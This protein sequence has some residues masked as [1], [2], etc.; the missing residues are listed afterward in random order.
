[1]VL[2]NWTPTCKNKSE[3]RHKPYTFRNSE[4][5]ID[6]SVKCKPIKF[7]E[8]N[9]RENLGD[10]RYGNAFLNTTPMAQ[11]MKDLIDKLNF[12]KIKN[13]AGN[14]AFKRIKRKSEGGRK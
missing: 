2:N 7:L 6:L 8:N 14:D 13:C 4:W 12:T 3:C 9:K 10:L 5:I 1:M 11:S